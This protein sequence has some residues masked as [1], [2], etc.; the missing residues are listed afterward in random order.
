MSTSEEQQVY[1]ED[2]GQ[3]YSTSEY[4]NEYQ[5][6]EYSQ[7]YGIEYQADYYEHASQAVEPEYAY[8]FKH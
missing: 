4:Q 5:G 3:E 6:G 7:E 8:E 1:S 2:Q